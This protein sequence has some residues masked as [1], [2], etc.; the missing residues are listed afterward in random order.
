MK[1]IILNGSPKNNINESNTEIFINQFHQNMKQ[2]YPVRY[3]VR[4]DHTKLAAE[5]KDYDTILLFIPLYVHAMPGPVMSFIEMLEEQNIR[6]KNLGFIIQAGF[7][8]TAQEQFIERYFEQLCKI[9]NCNYLGTVSKG[10]SAA[11]YMFPKKFKKLFKLINELGSKFEES[12]EFDKEIVEKLSYPYNLSD[13]SL[14]FRGAMKAVYM[15][16]LD[17]IGWNMMLKQHNSFENRYDKPFLE[18]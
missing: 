17:D 5:L 8:E 2:K 12:K 13:Y 15:L 7:P 16:K 3:I 4:E 10:E 9:L 11:V 14:L 18:D 1:M 6:G